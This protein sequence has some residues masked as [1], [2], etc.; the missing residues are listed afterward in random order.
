MTAVCCTNPARRHGCFI[1]VALHVELFFREVNLVVLLIHFGP[2]GNLHWRDQD[3][4]LLP[5]KLPHGGGPLKGPP[6]THAQARGCAAHG[7][8]RHPPQSASPLP[9]AT[10]SFA[11]GPRCGLARAAT[12]AA[13]GRQS[14]PG[15]CQDLCRR[16]GSS[17]SGP[18]RRRTVGDSTPSH[19]PSHM[20]RVK[21]GRTRCRLALPLLPL[22]PSHS[23]APEKALAPQLSTAGDSRA[24]KTWL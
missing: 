19:A 10:V 12:P 24:T 13:G 17:E 3:F 5:S 20:S 2:K 23:A 14:P 16:D 21:R 4:Q 8:H 15:R 18:R 22:A 7:G 9:T 11:A 6:R 1:A